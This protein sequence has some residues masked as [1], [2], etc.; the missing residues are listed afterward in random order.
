MQEVVILS[1]VRT[2]VGT[3]QGSLK[4]KPPTELGAAEVGVAGGAESMSR[5][6]HAT[7]TF[8]SGVKM[9]EATFVDMMIGALPDPFGT[10]HM[11]VTA[12]NVAE[13]WQVGREEQD[14][15]AVESQR[16]AS[17]AIEE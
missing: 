15:F 2:A 12:E 9:G 10:G 7:Q 16:R 6:P 4:D 11:G 17:R 14:R 13:R 8:R 5:S 1:G 3:F